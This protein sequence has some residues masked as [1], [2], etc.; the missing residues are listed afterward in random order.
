MT[1]LSLFDLIY[2]HS[3]QYQEIKI[4]KSKSKDMLYAY[5]KPTLFLYKHQN[6][7]SIPQKPVNY[8]TF[9]YNSITNKD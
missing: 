1:L 2:S 3:L 6:H 9:T 8:T 7:P 5:T 4:I